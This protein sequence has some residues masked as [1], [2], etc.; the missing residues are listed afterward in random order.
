MNFLNLDKEHQIIKYFIILGWIACW[1]SISFN[2]EFFYFPDNYI[3]LI[4][5]ELDYLKLITFFRGISTLIFF[6]ILIIISII[7]TKK[8]NLHKSNYIF[9]I[10]AIFFIIQII[11]LTNT[12]NSKI[13]IYYIV[14]SLDVIIICFI[15]KNF[16]SE[17]ELVLIFNIT[18]IILLSIFIYFGAKYVI[19]MANYP[20]NLSLYSVWGNMKINTLMFE[21]PR[22]TG[23]ARTALII[24]IIS[25]ILMIKN[26]NFNF[27]YLFLINLTSFFIISLG[28]RTVIFLYILY[29]V[30]YIFLNKLFSLKKIFYLLS[31][32]CFLPLGMIFFLGFIQ[33]KVNLSPEYID[34]TK[35]KKN[36]S[37]FRKY[38]SYSSVIRKFP[39]LEPKTKS[40]FS[41]GRYNDWKNI[42]NKN[43]NIFY[44]VGTMGDRY[45]IQQS[46]SN[47]VFYS[48]ASS[49]VLGVIL[50]IYVS[51]NT[52]F[53]SILILIKSGNIHSN[54]YKLISATC[55][56][57][58]ILRSV[59]E[60]S[61]GVFGIDLI[62]FSLFLSI[63]SFKKKI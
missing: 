31:K 63:I 34:Q 51:I 43:P 16:F 41:S 37:I 39:P 50:I 7:L 55:L 57:I 9:F 23:L 32:F 19:T 44:G 56:I 30:F 28:S 61:Y 48:Y 12:N 20:I 11:G 62:L 22:P 8:K 33:E 2:P 26:N 38:M 35:N 42:I 40:D 13:N 47:L 54:R 15:F 10:I 52:F 29:L 27:F 46:A 17:K 45:L 14:G 36:Y 58:L 49:G 24:L 6:P 1:V 18:Y 3:I 21:N 60:T 53:T 4:F 59:L 5:E 25:S